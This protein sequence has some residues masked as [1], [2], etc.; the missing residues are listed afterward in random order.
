VLSVDTKK[1]E[2][3]G[4]FKNP[5]RTWR[6]Q[7][8]PRRVNA[9]DFRRLSE[10]PGIPYGADE[11]QRNRG[12]VNVGMTHDTAEFAVERLR[13][14]GQVLGRRYYATA[15]GLLLGADG[16]GSTGRR[17]RAWQFYLPQWA[18][19]L[20]IPLTVGPY[21][22]G[23]RKWNQI[24]HR[25]FSFLS[26][27]WQGQPL[28]SYETVVN[29]I[30]AT[31]TKT[32]LRGKATLDPK[33]YAVGIKISDEAMAQLHLAPHEVHPQWNYTLRPRPPVSKT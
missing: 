28:V 22:P 29:L 19:D 8:Q 18:D 26:L 27:N 13:R 30:G 7:G 1:K 11:L 33:E 12:F 24:E 16:G 4:A 25:L 5:G 31:R 20:G 17:T 21:P 32:G 2:Q 15:P 3:G 10:G 9:S 23:T 6:R 14:W